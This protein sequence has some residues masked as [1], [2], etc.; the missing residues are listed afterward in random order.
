MLPPSQA[1]ALSAPLLVPPPSRDS[2]ASSSAIPPPSSTAPS[3]IGRSHPPSPCC[4]TLKSSQKGSK[5]PSTAASKGVLTVQMLGKAGPLPLVPPSLQ[6][7][8]LVWPLMH[9]PPPMP[10]AQTAPQKAPHPRPVCNRP[11]PKAT[12]VG[13]CA[14]SDSNDASTQPQ[15][16]ALTPAAG[17]MNGAKDE[18]L[19]LLRWIDGHDIETQTKQVQIE[20]IIQAIMKVQKLE[21]PS[22]EDI[23]WI[24]ADV[25]PTHAF[26]FD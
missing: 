24:I 2:P 22:K 17:A 4:V 18:G 25:S 12:D 15:S 23:Q 11:A 5:Q 13:C 19:D 10:P 3:S 1:P 20:D 21:Q 16:K 8:T 7:S 9:P 14:R 6:W 26:L